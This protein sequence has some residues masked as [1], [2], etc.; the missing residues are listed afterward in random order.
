MLTGIAKFEGNISAL[1]Q[2]SAFAQTSLA[3][4]RR[5]MQQ[6]ESDL[7]SRLNSTLQL[8]PSLPGGYAKSGR[9][10]DIII[11]PPNIA[12]GQSI[13][14]ATVLGTSIE[15][16]CSGG[17]ETALA[18][19]RRCICAKSLLRRTRGLSTGAWNFVPN[20]LNSDLPRQNMSV[21]ESFSRTLNY[22]PFHF[23]CQFIV[24]QSDLSIH[25]HIQASRNDEH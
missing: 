17:E 15:N 24:R 25:F 10:T 5:D 13:P 8:H 20:G 21:L 12:S 2:Q 3:D 18:V 23:S 4:L 16:S 7:I 1:V 9:F 11:A 6:F 22:H 19:S 14:Q